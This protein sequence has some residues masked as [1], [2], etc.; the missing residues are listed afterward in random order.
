MS[1][2]FLSLFKAPSSIISSLEYFSK[3]ISSLEYIFSAFFFEGA[4]RILVKY[5][6]LN[7]ILRD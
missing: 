4:V 5:I 3:K 2:Y 6:G 7:G 1:V